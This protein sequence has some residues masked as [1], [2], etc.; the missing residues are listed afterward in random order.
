MNCSTL[1]GGKVACKRP[2]KFEVCTSISRNKED[3]KFSKHCD[4]H[5]QRL[6][7][8]YLAFGD[9]AKALAVRTL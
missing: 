3:N 5:A 2:A 8:D 9:T 6:F 1:I 4:E 7:A